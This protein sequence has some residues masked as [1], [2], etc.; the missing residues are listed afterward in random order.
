MVPNPSFELFD[1]CPPY[2]GQIHLATDW[3]AP[4][5][6]TADYFHQCSPS[7][8][9]ASVPENQLGNQEPFNGDAYA[10]IRTWLPI[11]EGNPIYREYLSAQ[12]ITSLEAGQEYEVSFMLSVAENSGYLSNDIGLYLS[13]SPFDSRSFYD[14]EPQLSVQS[15]GVLEDTRNWQKI[16]TLYV[17]EGGENYLIIG[18]F[19]DDTSMTRVLRND[20]LSPHVYYY[21]D[22]V[23]VRPC[24]EFQDTTLYIDTTLC[25]NSTLLLRGEEGADQYS[26]DNSSSFLEQTIYS[27]GIYRVISD[28]NCYEIETNYT[29]I[30]QNCDCTLSL[31]SP[32]LTSSNLIVNQSQSL[33]SYQVQLFNAA[34]QLLYQFSDQHTAIPHLSAGIYF[35]RGYTTCANNGNKEIYGKIVLIRT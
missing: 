13:P 3:D 7:E 35:W 20:Q 16:S 5:N 6:R 24:L 33:K 17:A 25:E 4:N 26:W 34:G 2:L 27:P 15:N 14:V 12:L 9:G 10:G 28:F 31:P 21:I 1:G 11:I 29:V 32:Q 30:T 18:N 23:Q 19:L 22:E 8:E